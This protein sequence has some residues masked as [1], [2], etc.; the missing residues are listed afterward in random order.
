MKNETYSQTLNHLVDAAMELASTKDWDSLT[1]LDLCRGSEVSLS[2]CASI[3]VTKAH[4]SSGLDARLDQAMLLANQ[5]IEE[6]QSIRDRLFDVVMGRFDAMEESRLAWESILQGDRQD[7]ASN[8]ARRAR[9]A[10]TAAW[11]LEATGIS[12]S[13]VEGAAKA[14][15]LARLLRACD[16][17][18]LGDGPDLAKTMAK[19]DQGL[20]DAEMWRERATSFLSLVSGA[21][22]KAKS[23]AEPTL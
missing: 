17:A 2:Q 4:V 1:L 6:G 19:L 18:W 8:L 13:S 15:A 12:S 5:K 3:R 22:P 9:R 16:G 23:A 21:L 7:L 11:A 14:L 10:R 20:R